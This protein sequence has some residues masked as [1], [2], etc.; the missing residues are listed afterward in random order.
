MTQTDMI[1]A[2]LEAGNAITALSALKH[3]GCLRLSGRIY[4]I[5]KAGY[6]VAK[7]MVRVSDG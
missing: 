1:R 6:P 4:D 2:H 3:Y 7:R 5:K